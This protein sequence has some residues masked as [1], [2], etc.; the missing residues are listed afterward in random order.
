MQAVP[1]PIPEDDNPYRAPQAELA[2][3][4]D[5]LH[6]ATRMQRLGA[7]LVDNLTVVPIAIVAAVLM[8]MAKDS[9]DRQFGFVG[10]VVLAILVLLAINLVGIYRSGQTIGK[11][12]LGI[13]VVR[14]DGERVDFARY[15]FMRW[16]AIALIGNIPLIGPFISL[17][18]VLLIFRDSRRCLH[19]DF[20]DTI[21]I[22]A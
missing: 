21:V 8:P 18:N 17:L 22:L 15:L 12:L 6:L 14:S 2:K 13:R 20:A 11:R 3:P 4:R 1:P 19:D 10:L 5:E 9:P 7:A 16:F